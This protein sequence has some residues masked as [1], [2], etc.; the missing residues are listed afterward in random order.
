MW[1]Q[2]QLVALA[3][4]YDHPPVEERRLPCDACRVL[5]VSECRIELLI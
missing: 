1:A 5:V 4:G 3:L 2:L